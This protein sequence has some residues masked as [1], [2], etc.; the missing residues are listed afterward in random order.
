MN[1]TGTSSLAADWPTR[2]EQARDDLQTAL[3][4]ARDQDRDGARDAL[5]L[6]R[7]DLPHGSRA[8]K[9]CQQILDELSVGIRPS[10]HRTVLLREYIEDAYDAAITD[11]D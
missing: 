7:G 1:T 2:I 3:F 6:C 4:L 9:L 10:F 5:I 11:Q 8:R